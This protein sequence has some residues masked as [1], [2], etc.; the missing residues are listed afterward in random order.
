MTR[1]YHI[2]THKQPTM[3]CVLQY[4]LRLGMLFLR[5]LTWEDMGGGPHWGLG[6]ATHTYKLSLY[7]CDPHLQNETHLAQENV[8]FDIT[9]HGSVFALT[10]MLPWKWEHLNHCSYLMDKLVQPGRRFSVHFI[11]LMLSVVCCEQSPPRLYL[12]SSLSISRSGSLFLYLNLFFSFVI[13]PPM[14]VFIAATHL[15][16]FIIFCC[17]LSLCR[18]LYIIVE[19]QSSVSSLIG[20]SNEVMKK[21]RVRGLWRNQKVYLTFYLFTAN[22]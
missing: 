7:A 19:D 10:H 11:I 13:F 16:P 17:L 4:R 12:L 22:S 2:F 21:V 20:C 15:H 14:S 1:K 3:C 6:K 5:I 18:S 8:G 9:G